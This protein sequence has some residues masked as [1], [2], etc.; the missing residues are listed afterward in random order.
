MGD[1][2]VAGSIDL[3]RTPLSR[4][5]HDSCFIAAVAERFSPSKGYVTVCRYDE[6]DDPTPY[7][8]DRYE[9]WENLHDNPNLPMMIE[10]SD[11]CASSSLSDYLRCNV[12]LVKA[13]PD[14][15]HWQSSV[16]EK[17]RIA[18]EKAGQT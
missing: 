15:N 1:T 8:L 17:I 4:V 11:T 14:E 2:G 3:A 7:N 10:A 5:A 9:A 12:F 18:M 6:Q 13:Q 16:P